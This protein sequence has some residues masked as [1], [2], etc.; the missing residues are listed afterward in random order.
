MSKMVRR[1]TAPFA[2]ILVLFSFSVAWT[3]CACRT[4]VPTAPPPTKAAVQAHPSW[5]P[6]NARPRVVLGRTV[7]LRFDGNREL[8]D[9]QLRAIT[10]IDKDASPQPDQDTLVHDEEP[11]TPQ[12]VLERDVALL[13]AFYYDHGYLLV[14]IDEP[15]V[16]EAKDGPFLDVLVRIKREG[17]RLRV[18]SL[19]I[20]ERDDV[21]RPIPSPGNI[22]LRKRIPLAVGDWF[23]RDVIARG[24]AEIRTYYRDRGYANVETDPETSIREKD[25]MVDL[26]IPIRRGPLVHV[27]R[28]SVRGNTRT[29]EERV[30]REVTLHAGDLFSETKLEDSKKR[31]RELGLFARVE[32]ELRQE[33]DV[34]HVEI[35]FA[36]V[37]KASNRPR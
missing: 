17:P 33:R 13:N 26:V 37:E 27:E 23:A 24:L 25:A 6:L 9:A 16:T 36:V 22:D 14:Q 8:S 3:L 29:P 32:V 12:E 18:G 1:S 5:P 28:L 20:R 30:L 31:L 11:E 19:T 2:G 21:G 34:E 35:T 7:R 4:P 10:W 15:V